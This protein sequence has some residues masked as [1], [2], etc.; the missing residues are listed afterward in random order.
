MRLCL[1][2]SN[3]YRWMIPSSLSQLFL[4]SS[5]PTTW[6]AASDDDNTS[7]FQDLLGFIREF[8]DVDSRTDFSQRKKNVLLCRGIKLAL[9]LYENIH[10]LC[11]M[12]EMRRFVLGNRFHKQY[13][14]IASRFGWLLNTL[15]PFL[16]F[17]NWKT[18]IKDHTN[19]N[20]LQK[21]RALE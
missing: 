7:K 21:S 2:L 5:S 8:F 6:A 3:K 1:D 4:S 15:M 11:E 18:S 19:L 10:D 13:L 9:L 12:T 17:E 20:S 16:G 14:C